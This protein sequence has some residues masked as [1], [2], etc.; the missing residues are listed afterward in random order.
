MVMALT[1]LIHHTEIVTSSASNIFQSKSLQYQDY[2]Q[3][4]F[5]GTIN[6]SN[7][8][9]QIYFSSKSNNEVYTLKEMLQQP[10]KDQFVAAMEKEVTSMFSHKIW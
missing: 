7:P 6:Q 10:D 9:A 3:N 8:L 4:N 2:L 1:L 5:D